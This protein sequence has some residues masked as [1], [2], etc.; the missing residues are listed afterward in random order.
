[1]IYTCFISKIN[2]ILKTYQIEDIE[3]QVIIKPP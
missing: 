3:P 2:S 1:L